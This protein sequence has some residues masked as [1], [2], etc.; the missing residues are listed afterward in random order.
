M[1]VVVVGAS[2]G[3]GL[4]AGL[5]KGRLLVGCGVVLARCQRIGA[6]VVES[7]CRNLGLLLLGVV[8][9][10]GRWGGGCFVLWSIGILFVLVVLVV[11]D[12]GLGHWARV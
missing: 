8:A 7:M 6:T 9:S 1:F 10:D 2:S 4:V 11:G 5:G 12:V 3:V